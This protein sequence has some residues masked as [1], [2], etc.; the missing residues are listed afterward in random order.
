VKKQ[1][2]RKLEEVMNTKTPREVFFLLLSNL[3]AC[4]ASPDTFP[5]ELSDID[6]SHP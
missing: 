5:Q 3:T 2:N 6:R 1:A 4:G